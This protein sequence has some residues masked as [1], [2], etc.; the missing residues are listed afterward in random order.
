MPYGIYK[1]TEV[2]YLPSQYL[3]ELNMQ[4]SIEK[5]LRDELDQIFKVKRTHEYNL[6]AIEKRFYRHKKEYRRFDVAKVLEWV[7]QQS[8][9]DVSEFSRMS[10]L[11]IDEIRKERETHAN[12]IDQTS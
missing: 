3:Q 6:T 12:F 11:E 5:D 4:D 7:E 2:L 1:G 8:E 9:E 10:A